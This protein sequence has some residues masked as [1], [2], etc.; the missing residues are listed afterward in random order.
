MADIDITIT[1]N[2]V[3]IADF[4]AG[5]L[6]ARPKADTGQADLAYFKEF[7][8]TQLFNIY[9]TGKMQIAKET[10]AAEINDTIVSVS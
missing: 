8:Q 9:R 10:T 4:K 2:S 7:I 1:I 6:K 5:F 3:D